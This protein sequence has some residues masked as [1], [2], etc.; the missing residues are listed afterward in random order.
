MR[1]ADIRQ[2]Q[3]L[4]EHKG[5]G[6]GPWDGVFG[7]ETAAAC[8]RAKWALGYVEADC[9]PTM[10]ALLHDY[11]T[12][13]KHPSFAMDARAGKRAKKETKAQSKIE[14]VLE[15]AVRYLGVKEDPPGSN[16]TMFD[17]WYG[18]IGPWCAAF[19]SF[20]TEVCSKTGVKFHYAYVPFVVADARAHRNGLSVVSGPPKDTTSLVVACFDWPGESRGVADHI[21]FA[22]PESF[23]AQHW[24][25]TLTKATTTWG[26]P[27]EREFWCIEG[28]TS[29][30]SDSNGGEVWLRRRHVA[31]VQAFVKVS[32]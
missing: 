2:A 23:L 10:G 3:E 1:G 30:T 26:K 24:P 8:K 9:K 29:P 27:G 20:V 21:G 13:L 19:V 6:P 12:G 16:I 15:C 18:F 17:K 14:A 31:D 32:V 5:F 28:N 11:L 25:M 4:L 22:V 7:P